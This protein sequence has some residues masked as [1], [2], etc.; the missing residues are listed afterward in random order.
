[1]SNTAFQ[2]ATIQNLKDIANSI[3]HDRLLCSMSDLIFCYENKSLEEEEI[4][5]L[6]REVFSLLSDLVVLKNEIATLKT[7][8]DN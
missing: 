6:S 2:N 4:Y 7:E 5:N 1:M 8:A 3:N